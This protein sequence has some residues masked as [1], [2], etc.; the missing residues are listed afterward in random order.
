M[1][2]TG[3]ADDKLLSDQPGARALA[4]QLI[5]RASHIGNLSARSANTVFAACEATYQAIS[6]CIGVSGAKALLARAL[7]EANKTH[8]LLR[9]IRLDHPASATLRIPISAPGAKGSSPSAE[10]LEAL[11]EMMITLLARFVGMDMVI[12]LVAQRATIGTMEHE[13]SQ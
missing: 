9:N 5:A 3:A 6:R 1:A 10:G 8:P 2:L 13:D 12:Q 11:L 4:K 7:A